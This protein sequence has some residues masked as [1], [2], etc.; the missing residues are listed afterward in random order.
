MIGNGGVSAHVDGCRIG[1]VRQPGRRHLYTSRGRS[2]TSCGSGSSRCCPW[3][4]ATTGIPGAGAWRNRKVL[5]GILFVFAGHD[6]EPARALPGRR[7]WQRSSWCSQMIWPRGSGWPGVAIGV[8]LAA[9]IDSWC[10]RRAERKQMR[11][12]LIRAGGDLAESLGALES[13]VSVVSDACRD[14]KDEPLNSPNH[15]LLRRQTGAAVTAFG[16][17]SANRI[18]AAAG[19]A[20]NLITGRQGRHEPCRQAEHCRGRRRSRAARSWPE[21]AAVALGAFPSVH[22]RVLALLHCGRY[23]P[24]AAQHHHAPLPLPGADEPDA[25]RAGG[26]AQLALACRDRLIHGQRVAH[27]RLPRRNRHPRSPPPRSRRLRLVM[28]R[29]Q[30]G[31]GPPPT[32]MGVPPARRRGPL[33]ECRG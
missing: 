17:R 18:H 7:A 29:A 4:S 14:G 24:G 25:G 10:A 19:D 30:G 20:G 6:Q 11:L 1:G 16:G 26:L 32:A 21:L 13:L 15:R 8:V 22:Q 2:R 9:G 23:A 27:S 5:C 31:P 33:G 12:D 3:S 28:L